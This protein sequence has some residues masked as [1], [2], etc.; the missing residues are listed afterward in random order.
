MTEPPPPLIRCGMDAFMTRNEPVRL[1][2]ITFL[3]TS[4]SRSVTVPRIDPRVVDHHIEPASECQRRVDHPLHFFKFGHIPRTRR[5]A[6]RSQFL[7]HL[8][9][10]FLATAGDT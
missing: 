9:K 5:D 1:V 2:S 8:V 3:Q 6:S 4:G 7:S 10:H